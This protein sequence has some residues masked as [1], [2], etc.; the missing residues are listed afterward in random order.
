MNTIK[1]VTPSEAWQILQDHPI[2]TQVRQALLGGVGGTAPVLLICRSG[3][4]SLEAGNV[5]VVADS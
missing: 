2:V 1:T 3:V 4:R 5:L